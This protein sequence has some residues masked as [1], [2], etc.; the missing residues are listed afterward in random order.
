MKNSF[1]KH[2]GIAWVLS[3]FL[4]TAAAEDVVGETPGVG[5]I[6]V[7]V[8][9]KA[10]PDPW[11]VVL[12]MNNFDFA[13]ESC[14]NI[15]VSDF[16][17][18]T[19][20]GKVERHQC[21]YSGSNNNRANP[22]CIVY[23]SNGAYVQ[24]RIGWVTKT[25]PGCD[26]GVNTIALDIKAA[27]RGKF[28]T[29]RIYR[30]IAS[31]PGQAPNPF[32]SIGMRPDIEIT[33][34]QKLLIVKAIDQYFNEIWVNRFMD[35]KEEL[36]VKERSGP[37]LE[38][39]A[40][41]KAENQEFLALSA[42]SAKTHLK[43][44]WSAKVVVLSTANP[45][46]AL[47]VK[48]SWE[49]KHACVSQVNLLIEPDQKNNFTIKKILSYDSISSGYSVCD[50]C[51]EWNTMAGEVQEIVDSNQ[52]GFGEILLEYTGFNSRVISILEYTPRGFVEVYNYL[53]GC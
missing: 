35:L 49:M 33:S 40:R 39:I 21:N 25:T 34:N 45:I 31:C 7:E 29:N 14:S 44:N 52:N 1:I 12:P 11:V 23:L 48:A 53:D 17:Q 28:Y 18:L 4:V 27:D 6:V 47:L 20:G 46:P 42:E 8:D 32:S 19:S 5:P 36:N 15:T 26:S 9:M 3:L 50:N 30:L 38:D 13:G 2:I 37:P 22:A 41:V 24:G 51:A 16:V 10:H 43:M